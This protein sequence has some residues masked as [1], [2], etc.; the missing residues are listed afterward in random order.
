MEMAPGALPHPGRV[1]EQRLSVP[2]SPLRWR[3]C[4]GTFRGWRLDDLGFLHRQAL[5]GERGDRGGAGGPH[6]TPWRGLAWPAPPGVVGPLAR[7]RPC[8][9]RLYISPEAK[10]LDRQSEI[11]KKFHSATATEGEIWGTE[12]L[13]S[14]TLPGRGSA[15][16]AISIDLHRHLHHHC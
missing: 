12:S 8:L 10:T 14:G 15:P 2:E 1:P 16:G 5:I 4:C 9:I 11:H 13:C 7:Y 6:T 3:R